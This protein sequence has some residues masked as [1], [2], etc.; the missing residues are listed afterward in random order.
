VVTNSWGTDGAWEPHNP[1]NQATFNLYRSGFVVTFAAGNEGAQGES[2]LNKYCV[3]PWVL[4]VAAGDYLSRRAPF[5]SMGT[6]PEV[7]D[8]AYDH[9]DI[10]APGVGIKAAKALGDPSSGGSVPALPVGGTATREYYT[11]KSGTSMATP[12]VAGAAALLISKNPDLSPDNV[13]DILVAS[14]TPIAPTLWQGGAG[15]LNVLDAYRTAE[16]IDGNLAEF[17]EG[18]VK[19]GG[20]ATGDPTFANDPTSVGLGIGPTGGL[21]GSDTTPTQFVDALVGTTMGLVF[22][23]GTLV[24]GVMS[25]APGRARRL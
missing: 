11:S 24:L 6:D 14:A 4:C 8:K 23:I 22:L 25:F 15:Y 10:M 19:Y 1:V 5:S 7:S 18:N 12:V 9:P 16:D 17:K 2:T 13:Y 21:R 20:K 3:A